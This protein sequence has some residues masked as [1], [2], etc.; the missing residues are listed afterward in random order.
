MK[1]FEGKVI[2]KKMNKT[3]TVETE[4]IVAHPLY[5]K[6]YKRTKTYHV[7]D[8]LGAEVGQAVKFVDCKPVSK[9][10]KWKIIEIIDPI[11]NKKGS[12]PEAKKKTKKTTGNKDLKKK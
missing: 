10:K 12:K 4:R 2:S 3:A 9:L 11:T 5:R 7:H 6:R 1:V 8:E